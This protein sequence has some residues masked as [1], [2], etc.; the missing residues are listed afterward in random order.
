MICHR[1]SMDKTF[2]SHHNTVIGSCIRQARM[3][4]SLEGREAVMLQGRNLNSSQGREMKEDF[5]PGGEKNS[6][7]GR[8]SH[9]CPLRLSLDLL[10]CI[11]FWPTSERKG[12][13]HWSDLAG[14]WA[15]SF[16]LPV[17][18]VYNIFWNHNEIP[19]PS[20]TLA[21]PVIAKIPSP[22]PV[23]HTSTGNTERS[24]YKA[25]SRW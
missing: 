1:L 7:Q 24:Q 18:W 6:T 20:M 3:K 12:V 9:N 13:D 21:L 16:F 11:L 23:L 15:S 4:S 14:E 2:T 19:F 25:R 10:R 5:G 8:L 17:C 22:R